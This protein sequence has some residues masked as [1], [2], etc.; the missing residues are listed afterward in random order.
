[1]GA[2]FSEHPTHEQLVSYV[3]GC[4][5]PADV[6]WI[7][8]HVEQCAVCREDLTDLR[9]VQEM[10]AA[11]TPAGPIEV[12]RWPRWVIGG[13][14]AA[15]ILGLLWVNRPGP[16]PEERQESVALASQ[17]AAEEPPAAPPV[18]PVSAREQ[19]L[20]AEAL[21]TGVAPLAPFDRAIRVPAGT[22]LN[23]APSRA[24]FAP[25]GPMATALTSPR[26]RFAWTAAPDATTYTVSVF[27]ERFTEVA[28]SGPITTTEWSPSRD[29]PRNQVL[30]WQVV[31]ESPAGRLAT[32]APPQPEARVL[33]L[34]EE[35]ARVIAEARRRLTNEPL[36]L[37]LVLSEAGLYADAR[38]M[39]SRALTDPRYDASQV[40]AILASLSH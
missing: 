18:S 15:G 10:L 7:D 22:L 2:H 19:Q 32:P 1:M 38:A 28:S 37:G 35:R 3:D 4:L 34:P 36:A 20:L 8:S 40:R 30:S 6:E 12:R 11:A 26:P 27:D 31:A 39:L 9:Q 29:L 21:L 24:P 13:A 14:A 33:I 16:A 25:T 5:H 23:A 17:P